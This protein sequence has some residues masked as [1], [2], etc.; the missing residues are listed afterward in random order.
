MSCPIEFSKSNRCMTDL[1]Q[2]RHLV[3]P[4]LRSLL[5]TLYPVPRPSLCPAPVLL[6]IDKTGPVQSSPGSGPFFRVRAWETERERGRRSN[7]FFP[8]SQSST[9]PSQPLLLFLFLSFFS[10]LLLPLA[11]H[12]FEACVPSP[13]SVPPRLPVTAVLSSP[14]LIKAIHIRSPARQCMFAQDY[15]LHSTVYTTTG[16]HPSCIALPVLTHNRRGSYL[17]AS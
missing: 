13:D 3:S 16:G 5:G 8:L 6:P 10:S 4:P 17:Q 2:G 9:I 12:D 1:T 7:V 14:S 11:N 15:P